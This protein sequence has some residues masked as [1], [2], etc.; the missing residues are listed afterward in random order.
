[1][2]F[3]ALIVEEPF[4]FIILEIKILFSFTISLSLKYFS[5]FVSCMAPV[6]WKMDYV[7]DLR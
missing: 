7:V 2:F 3:T 6:G 5:L 1:M 4:S